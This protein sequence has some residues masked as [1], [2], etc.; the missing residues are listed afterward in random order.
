MGGVGDEHLAAFEHPAVARAPGRGAQVLHVR[1]R[2]GLGDRDGADRLP[3]QETGAIA[4]DL[5]LA[6]AV[7]KMGRGHVRMDQDG[8]RE[9]AIGG[10]PQLFRQDDRGDGIEPRAAVLLGHPQAEEAEG[11]EAAQHLARDHAFLLP[12]LA[13]GRHLFRHEAAELVADQA[14]LLVEMDRVQGVSPRMV[15]RT[16]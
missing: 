14:V 10:A 5:R 2:L 3:A 9:A 4:L 13:V 15:A 16:L 12:R 1:A 11:A 6:A 7:I 8:D